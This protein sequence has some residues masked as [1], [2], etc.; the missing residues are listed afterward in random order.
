MAGIKHL[1]SILIVLACNFVAFGQQFSSGRIVFERKTNLKKRFGDN[2]RMKNFITE[3]NKYRIENFEL[4]FNDT[5]CVFRPIEDEEKIDGFMK[6]LTQKNTVYQNLNSREKFIAMDM[7]G[8]AI[9]VKDSMDSRKWKITDSKRFISGYNCRKAIWEMNDSTRIYAWF[10]AEIVP[11]FG[12]EGF[13]GLPG[14]ILGLATEDGGV[15]Y[16][17]KEVKAQ[18]TPKVVLEYSEKGKEIYTENQLK[19][20]L[21]QRVGQW[22][23]PE[24]IDAMFSWL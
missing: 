6:F 3:Q 2:P 8:N 9:Y 1:S 10:A 11:S 22:M 14:A 19:E 13:E 7:W 15:I 4:L 17:A 20:F 5:S 18:E 12:P 24:D 16:F 21:K 23:K